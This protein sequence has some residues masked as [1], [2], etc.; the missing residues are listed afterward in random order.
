MYSFKS[1][2][3]A[4]CRGEEC[5]CVVDNGDS[6]QISS[7]D[8]RFYGKPSLGRL[9]SRCPHLSAGHADMLKNENVWRGR[10]GFGKRRS[11]LGRL[12]RHG[13]W[14]SWRNLNLGVKAVLSNIEE[15]KQQEHTNDYKEL[16]KMMIM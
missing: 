4:R 15:E 1:Y 5:G 8:G 14:E 13:S 12:R 2:V 11:S 6:R 9:L 16:N 10:G 3:Q 7:G